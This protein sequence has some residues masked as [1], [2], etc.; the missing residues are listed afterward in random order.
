[1]V[2][3]I[4]HDQLFIGG[5]WA[6]PT[7]SQQLTVTSPAT[8]DVIATVPLGGIADV[9]AAISLARKAFDEGPWPRMSVDERRV[10]IR[11]FGRAL[12]HDVDSLSRL[13]SSDT[14]QL[15][16][17]RHGN[18][19]PAFDYY[20]SLDLPKPEYRVAPDGAAALIVHEPVG[21]VAAVMPWNAPMALTLHSILPALLAGCPVV[22][23]P[24]RETPL[25]AFPLA[26]AC[27][28]AGLPEGVLS[29]VTCDRPAS[30]HLVRHPGVD[31]IAL[32]GSTEAGI[33]IGTLC[34]EQIKRVRLEL[35]GK[36]AAIFLDDADIATAAPLALNAGALQNNGEACAAWTRLLVP[37]SREAE[38]VDALCDI[39]SGVVVGDPLDEATGLGPMVSRQQR[40]TVERYIEIGAA[41]G[42]KIAFGGGRPA[43]LDRGWFVEP[44]LLTDVDNSMQVAREEIF[45]PVAVVIP[46]DDVDDAVRIANDSPFG[47]AGGVLTQD[48]ARGVA[49]AQRIRAGAIG[50]NSLGYGLAFPFGG[51][52]QS[53]IGREHGPESLHELLEVKTIGLP[54]DHDRAAFD[55]TQVIH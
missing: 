28:D 18:V 6:Q 35:G 19:G 54:R 10:L 30:E 25:Y 21:V 13:I 2:E 15:F 36:S 39:L 11:A 41:E 12:G 34:A 22:I 29:V 7:G 31:L 48:H 40:E 17:Y 51:Y 26:Q 33:R 45:G 50:V 27:L 9:D 24:P 53:G 55:N 4:K 46:Y 5:R 37:R 43:H 49:V 32:V 38:I 1:M 44:T 42:A 3:L 47:L 20:S 14:G 8:E 52:K 16:R 23:K